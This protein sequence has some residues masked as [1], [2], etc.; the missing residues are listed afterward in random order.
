MIIKNRAYCLSCDDEIESTHRHDYVTCSCGRVSVDGGK[1]Y[2]RRG[3][4]EGGMFVDTSVV[5]E[6]EEVEDDS[7]AG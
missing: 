7:T 5:V 3:F 6:K 4:K 2:L 1:D